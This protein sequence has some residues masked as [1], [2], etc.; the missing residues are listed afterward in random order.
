MGYFQQ[1]AENAQGQILL[2]L[3]DYQAKNGFCPSYREIQEACEISSTSV[4]ASHLRV[5][6]GQGRI[7]LPANGEARA[8]RLQH[9]IYGLTLHFTPAE[10]ERLRAWGGDDVKGAIMHRC[11]AVPL[12]MAGMETPEAHQPSLSGALEGSG[13]VV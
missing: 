10:A 5:L 12:P 2:F 3:E 4:V 13:G 11:E 6:A 1:R 9:H 8:I 7:E